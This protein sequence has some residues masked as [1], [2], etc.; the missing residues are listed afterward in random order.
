MKTLIAATA[1]LTV[2]ASA[3]YAGEGQGNPF[4]FRAPT[5]PYSLKTYKQAPGKSTDPYPFTVPG[6]PLNS[7]GVARAVGSVGEVQSLNSMPPGFVNGTPLA[8]TVRPATPTRMAQ[9]SG[10]AVSPHG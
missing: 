6:S 9:P 4:P 8:R 10:S 1:A 2:L 5:Q 3:A 7:A